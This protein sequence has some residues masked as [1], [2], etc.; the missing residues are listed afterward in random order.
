MHLQMEIHRHLIELASIADDK[1]KRLHVEIETQRVAKVN[2][3]TLV[4]VEFED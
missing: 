3:V 2:L 1:N 4:N